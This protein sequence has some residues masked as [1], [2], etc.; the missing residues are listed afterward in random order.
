MTVRPDRPALRPTRS[1]PASARSPSDKA[2]I[3]CREYSY[4]YRGHHSECSGS[5]AACRSGLTAGH[6]ADAG[7]GAQVA[8]SCRS[9]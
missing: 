8:R 2:D 9:S 4:L 1:A 3:A 7:T 5:S 6:A